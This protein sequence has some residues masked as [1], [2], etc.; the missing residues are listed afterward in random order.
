MSQEISLNHHYV[1]GILTHNWHD[2]KHLK[3][4]DHLLEANTMTHFLSESI[5]IT[6]VACPSLQACTNMTSFSNLASFFPNQP[7]LNLVRNNL[8]T[9][10]LPKLPN[11]RRQYDLTFTQTQW[12]YPGPCVLICL[13]F[14]RTP[15]CRTKPGLTMQKSTCLPFFFIYVTINL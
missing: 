8:Y 2:K 14:V 15:T 12:S 3:L 7:L 11:M 6:A 5:R 10:G 1:M 13:Q 4:Q 9:R